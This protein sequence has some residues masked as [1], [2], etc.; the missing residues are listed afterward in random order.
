M[1]VA[2]KRTDSELYQYRKL[3]DD[4]YRHATGYFVLACESGHIGITRV[5]NRPKRSAYARDDTRE[6]EPV[7]AGGRQR[8]AYA[9]G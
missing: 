2:N 5:G 6:S 8:R 3:G 4:D 9:L 1:V 7:F